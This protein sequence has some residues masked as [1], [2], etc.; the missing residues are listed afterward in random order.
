[1]RTYF[2]VSYDNDEQMPYYDIIAAN[3]EGEAISKVN[4]YSP[5]IFPGA[6]CALTDD[7]LNKI[8]RRIK[9]YKWQI[10][11]IMFKIAIQMTPK[12]LLIMDATFCIMVIAGVIMLVKGL[13]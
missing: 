1:M 8:S 3:S 13:L 9:T 5:E 4:E 12:H 11:W 7:S 2:V 6:V 10:R